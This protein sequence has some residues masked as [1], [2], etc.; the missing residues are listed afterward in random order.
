M[1]N[2]YTTVLAVIGAVSGTI[3]TGIGIFNAWRQYHKDAVKISLIWTIES[4]GGG[5]GEATVVHSFFI[6][7]KSNYAI[8]IADVGIVFEKRGGQISHFRRPVL[9][10]TKYLPSHCRC[11]LTRVTAL[12]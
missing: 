3:R 1:L 10:M 9:K 12:C 11:G 4:W 8:T 5:L 2:I 7:N 6:E